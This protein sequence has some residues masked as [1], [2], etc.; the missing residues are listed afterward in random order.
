MK[1]NTL[2]TTIN[3][4]GEKLAAEIKV[5][6]MTKPSVKHSMYVDDAEFPFSAVRHNG[7]VSLFYSFLDLPMSIA[8]YKIRFAGNTF[9]EANTI[10]NR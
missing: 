5:L 8:D 1:V 10:L 2:T 4:A 7:K 3:A 6:L 9:N